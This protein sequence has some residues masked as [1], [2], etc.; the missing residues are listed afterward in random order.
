[1]LF[2]M[3]QSVSYILNSLG[4]EIHRK[5]ASPTEHELSNLESCL[6]LLLSTYGMVN[7]VQ[8]GA[9][10]GAINDPIYKFVSKYS[11][12]TRIILSEP[13][14]YLIPELEKNY[15]F[16]DQKYVFNGAV[17]PDQALT[18]HRVKQEYWPEFHVPYA[19][20]WPQ[21]RAPT[22]ITSADY[23]HVLTWVRRYYRGNYKAE[24]IIETVS[25]EC[26]DLKKLLRK[27]G[28]FSDV[29]V[30]QIDAEG[31]DDQVIYSSDIEGISPLIINFECGN[32]TT[33]RAEDIREFLAQNKYVLSKHGID[34]M[35]IRTLCV[36]PEIPC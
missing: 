34:G 17:G 27:A 6:H 14:S 1:M 33:Q 12:R 15:K 21:Y 19:Q 18:L 30:L 20:G 31:F 11:E 28:L 3:K 8:V 16:H 13:Q 23:G 7:I 36:S 22:G 4:Y 9:N 5:A 32:L 10:D 26:V 35:A 2:R 24:E 25:V 29:H